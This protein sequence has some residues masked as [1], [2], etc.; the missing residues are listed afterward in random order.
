MRNAFAATAL[1][2]ASWSYEAKADDL[3]TIVQ[4][5]TEIY[6]LAETIFRETRGTGVQE[7][8]LVGNV[9]YNRTKAD[10][11]AD[12]LCGVMK[13]KGQFPW[14][15]VFSQAER[16]KTIKRD[17]H[18]FDESYVIA[19]YIISRSIDDPTNG[20][21][22]FHARDGKSHSWTKGL[23]K[24]KTTKHHIYYKKKGTA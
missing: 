10:G 24:V 5:N 13:Q 3:K 16:M 1:L 8:I 15:N 21:L 20:A 11:F 19:S 22:F 9:V 17:K 18:E 12:T 2:L 23:R 4:G 7:K 6:C 14:I